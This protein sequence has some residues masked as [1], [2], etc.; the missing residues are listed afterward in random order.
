MLPRMSARACAPWVSVFAMVAG[1]SHSPSS[2]PEIAAPAATGTTHVM[3]HFDR[4]GGFYDA[5]FP[6]DDLR[7]SD[8]TINLNVFPNPNAIEL[9]SQAV[10]LASQLG[11]FARSGGVFFQTTAAVAPASLPDVNTSITASASA[12]LLAV[13]PGAPDYLERIP[14]QVTYQADGGPFGS[15]NLLALVPI[16]GTPMRANERYAAVVTTAVKDT[17]GAPLVPSPEMAALAAGVPP[18]TMSS[19]AQQTYAA[20]LAALAKAGIA[21]DHLVG[22][23]AFTTGDPT[24]QF[25]S[26]SLTLSL[27]Q[28]SSPMRRSV[29]PS[30][31]TTIASSRAPSPF[32]IINRGRRRI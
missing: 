11:T 27:A 16:Q 19:P 14:V 1:C 13:D 22:L 23:A 12:F 10:S 3:M 30:R 20:A 17:T 24:S 15:P 8:G 31:S 29:S 5:P 28:C 25:G 32:L 2:P 9:M 4:S 7:A 26:S 6:S 21:A 18:T